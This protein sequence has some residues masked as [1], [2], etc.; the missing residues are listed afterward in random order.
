MLLAE[1]VFLA[2]ETICQIFLAVKTVFSVKWK[3][4]FNEFFIPAS[5]NGKSIFLFRALLK[6]LKF[7]GGNSCL[8]K[9]IFWL[10]ELSRT[11]PFLRYP[12]QSK[13]FSVQWKSIFKQI[14]QS[15][16]WRRI[17]CPAETVFSYLI[18]FLHKWKPSL[19]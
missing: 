13:L 3:R 2:S 17:F 9:L 14:L 7:E 15:S 6:L 19:K 11:F 16:W 12:F 8:W 10:V 4:F 1:T 18:F 5:R